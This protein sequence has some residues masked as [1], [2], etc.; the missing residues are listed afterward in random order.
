MVPFAS[1]SVS[2]TLDAV[3]IFGIIV[4]SH[5]GFQYVFLFFGPACFLFGDYPGL[6]LGLSLSWQPGKDDKANRNYF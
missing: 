2:P 4:H 5:I 3:L 6:A 1:G